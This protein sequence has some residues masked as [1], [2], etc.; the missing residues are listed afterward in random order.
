M[1]LS[2]SENKKAPAQQRPERPGWADAVVLPIRRWTSVYL[3]GIAIDPLLSVMQEAC[4]WVRNAATEGERS[5]KVSVK[6]LQA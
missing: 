3:G 4:Q 5:L 1:F 2:R 6:K